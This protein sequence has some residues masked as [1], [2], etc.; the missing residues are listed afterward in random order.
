MC[1]F[2]SSLAQV[3]VLNNLLVFVNSALLQNPFCDTQVSYLEVK[4]GLIFSASLKQ[5]TNDFQHFINQALYNE[6]HCGQ[7]GFRPELLI[8]CFL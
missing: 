5:K 7:A 6:M 1:K 4:V 2:F 3:H 8:L